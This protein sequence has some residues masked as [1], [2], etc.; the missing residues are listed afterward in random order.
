[1]RRILIGGLVVVVAFVA[2]LFLMTLLWPSAPTARPPV[3]EIPPLKPA[4]RTS[5]VI[6]PAAIALSA[7]RDELDAKAPRDLSGKRDNPIGQ[8]LQNAELGWN[9]NRGPLAVSG[10]P[11]GMTIVAPLNGAF[12]LTGQ[13][14]AQVGNVDDR[15]RA[16]R[17]PRRLG[18]RAARQSHRQGAR[19]ARRHPRQRHAHRAPGA[20]AELAH[21]AESHRPGQYR[22]CEPLGRG[23][24]HQP[25][26]GNEAA[27]RSRGG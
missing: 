15:Q 19:S 3:A 7:I 1:M 26:Q 4:T 27:A 8:L 20:A 16:R 23:R 10:R 11:E 21:R 17:H 9:I 18:R 14:G 13:I 2:A 6:A 12:R 24:A 25:R 5:T 22:R